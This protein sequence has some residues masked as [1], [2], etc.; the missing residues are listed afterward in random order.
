[1]KTRQPVRWFD[2]EWIFAAL[3]FL[4]LVT[5]V[6]A[7]SVYEALASNPQFL[8]VRQVGHARL[9]EIV[10]AFNLLPAVPEP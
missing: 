10:F 8:A 3:S 4:T 7:E 9:L 1:M 6:P 5:F 2:K